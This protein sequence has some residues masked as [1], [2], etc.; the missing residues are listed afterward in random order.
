MANVAQLVELR[1]VVP[2]VVSSSLIV[3]PILSLKSEGF[4]CEQL[5]ARFQR[6][7]RKKTAEKTAVFCFFIDPRNCEVCA[8]C[9]DVSIYAE[10]LPQFDVCAH[11]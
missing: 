4:F 1:F 9:S 7:C 6:I 3:R 8:I 2:A 10:L 5:M 11:G